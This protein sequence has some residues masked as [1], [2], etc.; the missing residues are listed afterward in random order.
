MPSKRASFGVEES[1]R[2]IPAIPLSFAV[3]RQL[4]CPETMWLRTP[5]EPNALAK[6][7]AINVPVDFRA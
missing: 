5:H 3:A 6:L 4:P 7:Q 1:G 2:Q